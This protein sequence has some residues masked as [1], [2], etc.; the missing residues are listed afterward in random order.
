MTLEHRHHARCACGSSLSSYERASAA[1][2]PFALAGTK[3]VYER[4]RPFRIR[5]IAIDLELVV[6]D[7]ALRGTATIDV[8]RVD[9]TA[10]EIALDA[11]G[12]ELT[13]VSLRDD[14]GKGK[15]GWE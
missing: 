10:T 5:H 4:P 11:V 12:F 2:R 6:D 7:K 1:P 13:E 3:R 9:P 15:K 14:Q 8:T